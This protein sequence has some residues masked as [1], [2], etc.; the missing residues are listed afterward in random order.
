M[1]GQTE[2]LLWQK[3]NL[4]E[5]FI[6]CCTAGMP[7]S[8]NLKY[9]FLVHGDVFP[10]APDFCEKKNPQKIVSRGGIHRGKVWD[11]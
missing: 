2:Y 9:F 6:Y 10:Q 11:H 5:R 4:S 3:R 8:F 7:S 1:I